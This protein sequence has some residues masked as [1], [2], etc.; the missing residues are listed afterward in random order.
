MSNVK[1]FGKF[2]RNDVPSS[3]RQLADQIELDD[4]P[5]NKVYNASRCIVLLKTQD[6]DVIYWAFGTDTFTKLEAVGM[7][8][9]AATAF[10]G[11]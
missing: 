1:S 9:Y 2:K 8:S 3:L 4:S 11:K 6:D 7:C 10:V 5:E